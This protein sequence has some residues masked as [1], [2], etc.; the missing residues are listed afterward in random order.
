MNAMIA[1]ED[2][3]SSISFVGAASASARLQLA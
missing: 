2:D 3:T 1:K